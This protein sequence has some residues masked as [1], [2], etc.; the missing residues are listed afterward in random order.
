M[1]RHVATV[2]RTTR[3]VTRTPLT[4]TVQV[5]SVR[6]VEIP[7]RFGGTSARARSAKTARV[8]PVVGGVDVGGTAGLAEGLL[9][10]WSDRAVPLAGTVAG[11]VLTVDPT[12]R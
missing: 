10:T 11:G 5:A 7:P 2:S 8:R 9:A 4:L 12:A 6:E 3:R 1:S